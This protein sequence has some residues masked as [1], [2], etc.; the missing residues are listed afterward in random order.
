MVCLFVC[1][2][3]EAKLANGSTKANSWK[4][5]LPSELDSNSSTLFASTHFLSLCK[6]TFGNGQ[7]WFWWW[8]WKH[9]ANV[10]CCVPPRRASL[11]A[12]SSWHPSCL[13]CSSVIAQVCHLALGN[14]KANDTIATV[15]SEFF[16]KANTTS[17]VRIRWNSQGPCPSY[18]TSQPFLPMSVARST[19]SSRTGNLLVS[20]ASPPKPLLG[21]S[22]ELTATKGLQTTNVLWRDAPQLGTPHLSLGDAPIRSSTSC[23]K[24][25]LTAGPPGT[26]LSSLQGARCSL[27]LHLY[28]TQSTSAI[29]KSA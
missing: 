29:L 6:H 12:V 25:F 5:Q 15:L 1:L 2:Y 3:F 22:W 18:C 24:R 21:L 14:Q 27:A 17:Q 11:R 19:L 16:E 20:F 10:T 4:C 13:L 28:S 26:M 7:G 9:R 8:P 23:P